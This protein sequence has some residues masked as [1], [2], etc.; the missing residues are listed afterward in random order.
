SSAS[1]SYGHLSASAIS[2]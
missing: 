2:P 1:G